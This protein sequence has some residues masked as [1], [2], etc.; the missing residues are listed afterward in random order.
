MKRFLVQ[1]L[2]LFLAA[3]PA[4]ALSL[5]EAKQRGLVGETPSGYLEAVAP[6]SEAQQLVVEINAK[7]TEAYKAIAAKNGAGVE[8]VAQIAGKEAIEKAPAGT[9]VKL[10]GG[11]WTRK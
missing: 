5:E 10:P 1:C 6:S 3:S 2:V 9:F 7:R 4:W 11:S 8:A